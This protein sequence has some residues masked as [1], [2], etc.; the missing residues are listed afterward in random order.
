MDRLYPE[1]LHAKRLARARAELPPNYIPSLRCG[2][3]AVATRE[4]RPSDWRKLPA[5]KH[6]RFGPCGRPECLREFAIR[7]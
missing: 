3:R 1:L 4:C 2:E 6:Y 5:R 7:K